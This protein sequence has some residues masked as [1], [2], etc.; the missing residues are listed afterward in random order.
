M[1]LKV[2]FNGDLDLQS[3]KWCQ[4]WIPGVKLVQKSGI[5]HDFRTLGKKVTF[6]LHAF[7]LISCNYA[8]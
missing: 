3:K 6:W 1:T 5:A 7:S 2:I 8:N 4:K